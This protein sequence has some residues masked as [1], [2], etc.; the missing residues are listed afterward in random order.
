[1]ISFF[2]EDIDFKVPQS[3]KI[4][5]W[6]KNTAET[7]G[8]KLNQLNYIFCSDEHLLNVNLQYLN[9]DFYTDIITFDNSEFENEIEGDIF[10]SIERVKENATKFGK[11]FGEELRR[12]LVH[13]VLHLVG[14]DDKTD[15]EE[16]KMREKEDFYLAIFP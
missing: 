4:K 11:S 10:V 8:C 13:G 16:I 15:D 7:E 3:R 9:H 14:F 12:V 1:M 2:S 5:A 6:I